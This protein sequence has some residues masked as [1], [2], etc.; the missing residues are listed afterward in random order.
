MSDSASIQGVSVAY[1]TRGLTKLIESLGPDTA[2]TRASLV[3]LNGLLSNQET[4]LQAVAYQAPP[5]V[6]ALVALLATEDDDVQRLAATALGS[7]SLVYQGRVA[8]QRAGAV[9]AL[10]RAF[11]ATVPVAAASA[12]ALLS[13][14]QSRDGCGVLMECGDTLVATLTVALSGPPAVASPCLA[15]LSNLLR[16]DLG[17]HD[18]LA[19]GIVPALHATILKARR[20]SDELKHA[21][22]AL[23]NLSNTHEGKAA[24]VEEGLLPTLGQ[25]VDGGECQIAN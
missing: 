25:K 17:V 11:S 12:T 10:E 14:S 15:T 5:L 16:L 18:A 13:L 20:E 2:L 1:G 6:P 8:A 24:V 9:A 23:W 19:A 21:L 22:Q 4:K 7:L 3:S